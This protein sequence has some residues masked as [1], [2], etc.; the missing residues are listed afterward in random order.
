[1][2][3]YCNT[4]AFTY[5]TLE[6]TN[7]SYNRVLI[8]KCGISLLEGKKKTRCEFYDKTI[9]KTKI[10]IPYKKNVKTKYQTY[11]INVETVDEK[12]RKELHWN[13]HLLKIA[14][15]YP[16]VRISTYMALIDYSLR[17]LQYKPFFPDKESID[18]LIIRLN[19]KPDD[20]KF[21]K[22]NN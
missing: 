14:H 18:Q 22:K 12:V 17:K 4:N 11:E 5:E 13:I 2:K 19:H 16:T 21:A 8:C 3:C 20:I 15:F 9:L 7:D 1:M 6:K 10:I